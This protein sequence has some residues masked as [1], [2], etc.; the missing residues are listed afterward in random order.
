MTHAP[1]PP[2]KHPLVASPQPAEDTAALRREAA[3][4]LSRSRWWR[5]DCRREL[6]LD[7]RWHGAPSP[8]RASEPDE[9]DRAGA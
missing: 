9:R 6:L 7:R 5:D 4:L 8:L 2:S 1:S 3:E